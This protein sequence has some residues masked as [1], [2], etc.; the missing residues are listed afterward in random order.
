MGI[1]SNWKWD[2]KGD[3]KD[4]HSPEL[5]RWLLLVVPW[6]CT[7]HREVLQLAD[8]TWPLLA[9]PLRWREEAD[10]SLGREFSRV[11]VK[12]GGKKVPCKWKK[13]REKENAREAQNDQPPQKSHILSPQHREKNLWMWLG[14]SERELKCVFCF[15]CFLA[16]PTSP[17]LFPHFILFPVQCN[18]LLEEINN[19]QLPLSAFLRGI[20]A[21]N[22]FLL[23]CFSVW[24]GVSLSKQS[25]DSPTFRWLSRPKSPADPS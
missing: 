25:P 16:F 11:W 3:L 2:G 10:K 9:F 4:C 12:M 17:L 21:S 20:A 1:E 8:M 5:W 13:C 6:K 15:N 24:G 14:P 19:S 18:G 22:S 23:I 7:D